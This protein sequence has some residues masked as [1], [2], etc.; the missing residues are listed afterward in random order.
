MDAESIGQGHRMVTRASFL[1]ALFLAWAG[2]QA[3]AAPVF[4]LDSDALTASTLFR[5]ERSTGR[6]TTLG[7]LPVGASGMA[8]VSEKVLYVATSTG[9]LLRV[10]LQPFE[11]MNLG[12]L[13]LASVVGIGF[14]AERLFAI[15]EQS[16][17]LYR[18]DVAPVRSVLVGA[19][20]LGD[21]G[22]PLLRLTGGDIA[23]DRLGNWYLWSNATG[24][25]YQLDVAT[26]VARPVGPPGGVAGTLT[27][28]AFDYDGD[29]LLASTGLPAGVSALVTLDTTSGLAAAAIGVCV[30]CPTAYQMRYGD[31]ASSPCTDADGDGF[32][33]V[34]G[35]CG[36]L[37][38]DDD[39]ATVHPGASERCDGIDDDC[40]GVVDE[41][42]DATASCGSSCSLQ[43]QCVAGGCVVDPRSEFEAVL[44]ELE[45]SSPG[46][47]CGVEPSDPAV[48]GF[49]SAKLSRARRLVVTAQQRVLANRRLGSIG[50]LA[51]AADRQ[52]SAL[53][54]RIRHI[55]DRAGLTPAC[56][57]AVGTA[58]GVVREM[59]AG[60]P[61]GR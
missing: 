35:T 20:R 47:V 36:P 25:L 9:D 39:S 31:M 1:A 54:R 32:S 50:R 4:Y 24:T 10:T 61:V 52:L 13:G 58:V 11:I 3:S 22:G 56:R 57:K 28:L 17:S 7:T 2:A 51:R 48:R 33:V 15:D 16:S 19:V 44:C 27:G 46:A 40:D 49:V 43:A 45:R 37:D 41:E 30:D 60:L 23:A 55:S 8:A 38:C 34:G 42:P 14:S 26:A 6:L 59:L 18:I 53:V 29:A 12:A 21:V 5:V